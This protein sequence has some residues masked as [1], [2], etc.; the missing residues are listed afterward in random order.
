M[1]RRLLFGK[2]KRLHRR[3]D[4]QRVF[5]ARCSVADRYLVVYVAP[6]GLGH[7][8]LGIP[9]GRKFGNAVRRNRVKR[10]I[11]EAFRIEQWDLLPGFDIICIPRPGDLG[12]QQQYRQSIRR[13]T[14]AAAKRSTRGPGALPAETGGADSQGT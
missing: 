14:A 5:A 1:S 6:N 7:S 11:R 4:F 3:R 9:V 12:D 2:S 10:L 8:R 13:L